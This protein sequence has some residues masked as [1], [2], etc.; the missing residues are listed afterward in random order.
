M[1]RTQVWMR[2]TQVMCP[3]PVQSCHLR[4]PM[5]SLGSKAYEELSVFFDFIWISLVIWG[6][7]SLHCAQVPSLPRLDSIW[8]EQAL[9]LNAINWW[10]KYT[11]VFSI[12]LLL[13]NFCQRA[14]LGNLCSQLGLGNRQLVQGKNMLAYNHI[15]SDEALFKIASIFRQLLSDL[16]GWWNNTLEGI[17]LQTN[18]GA[19]H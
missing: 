5:K 18:W 14:F 10:L 11:I 15:Y 9:Q 1:D 8:Q 19:G 4:H 16:W 7:E 3:E 12:I 17:K 2:P 6:L 13:P